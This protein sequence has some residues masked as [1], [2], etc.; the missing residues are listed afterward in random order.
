[1]ASRDV[2][3]HTVHKPVSDG[4]CAALTKQARHAL[5]AP[6]GACCAQM[7]VRCSGNCK[8]SACENTEELL[9]PSEPPPPPA[10]VP[11]APVAAL[12]PYAGTGANEW[13]AGVV[14]AG[15]P[16]A[17]EAAGVGPGVQPSMVL[18]VGMTP[19]AEGATPVS[20]TPQVVDLGPA[21]SS[22]PGTGSGAGATSARQQLFRRGGDVQ[23]PGQ[24][25][26]GGSGVGANLADRFEQ[27]VKQEPGLQAPGEQVVKAAHPISRGTARVLAAAR[28]LAPRLNRSAAGANNPSSAS[29][30]AAMGAPQLRHSSSGG[31][32]A[33]V[34]AGTPTRLQTPDQQTP[35]PASCTPSSRGSSC[36]GGGPTTAAAAWA[37]AMA[38]GEGGVGG[39]G[40]GR[41]RLS[42]SSSEGAAQG[43]QL[44]S[45]PE[46]AG[47]MPPPSGRPAASSRQA[48][49]AMCPGLA[50]QQQADGRLLMEC[51]E[52]VP[53]DLEPVAM[54]GAAGGVSSEGLQLGALHQRLTPLKRKLEADGEV[55]PPTGAAVG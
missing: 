28:E 25:V 29:K 39:A 7:G 22:G 21:M 2:R 41:H 18:P 27:A 50:E 17:V 36:D 12:T 42:T 54:M 14:P 19:G 4:H 6:C 11:A 51:D 5:T 9:G 13:V 3:E 24:G 46:G 40:R 1:M 23:A 44:A 45:L 10:S 48:A 38:A 49:E 31:A 20:A 43:L 8:C 37:A 15:L 53:A 30:A 16:V 26:L 35:W 47:L 32:T 52:T 34:D 33:G 55:S